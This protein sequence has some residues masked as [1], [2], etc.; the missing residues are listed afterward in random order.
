LIPGCGFLL[1]DHERSAL[2]VNLYLETICEAGLGGGKKLI[3]VGTG[4]AYS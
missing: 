3:S 1:A 2:L 4:D